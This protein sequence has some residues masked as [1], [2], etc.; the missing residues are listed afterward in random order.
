MQNQW[1]CT[2]NG[3][4]RESR[5]GGGG[6]TPLSHSFCIRSLVLWRCMPTSNVNG[7]CFDCATKASKILKLRLGD[8]G[9][10][11]PLGGS[12]GLKEDDN[13]NSDDGG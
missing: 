9:L 7:G 2:H 10:E 3:S 1:R 4:C 5:G 6:V 12:H 11:E 8:N 13:D